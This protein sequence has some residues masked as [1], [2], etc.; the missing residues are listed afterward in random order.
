MRDWFIQ[1]VFPLGT[2]TMDM[3]LMWSLREKDIM[4]RINVIK[5]QSILI[6]VKLILLCFIIVN[7]I[8]HRVH[9][10][11]FNTQEIVFLDFL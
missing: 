1:I 4:C 7:W 3:E 2:M 8:I 5:I 6:S 11:R 10:S 9:H